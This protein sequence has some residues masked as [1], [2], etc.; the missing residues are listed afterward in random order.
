VLHARPD[1]SDER[2]VEIYLRDQLTYARL[3][4]QPR[5]FDPHLEKWLNRINVPVLLLWGAGDH[6]IPPV[7]ADTFARL[8]PGAACETIANAGHYPQI[9]QPEAFVRAL[10]EFYQSLPA[11]ALEAVAR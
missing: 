8:I 5:L 3:A 9:E 7:Y 1:N 10:A 6:V 4:W 11:N 2:A